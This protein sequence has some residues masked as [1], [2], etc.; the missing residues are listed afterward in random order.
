MI[1]DA[2]S[3]RYVCDWWIDEF[4]TKSVVAYPLMVKGESIGAM[5]VETENDEVRFPQEEIDT[6]WAIAQQVAV[7]IEN[8]RLYEREQ[9]QRERSE[10]LRKLLTAAS[11]TLSL[12]QVCVRVCEAALDL[13]AGDNVSVF[14]LNESNDGFVP[15]S[16]VGRGSGE[17]TKAFFSPPPDVLYSEAY[18]NGDRM[19]AKLRK[20]LVA[21]NA[22]A[23]PYTHPW[24]TNTFGLKSIA[25]Y[26]L[27]V[28][29]RAIGLMIAS[30]VEKRCQF[31]EEEVQTL[32]AVAGQA[33]IMIENARLYER[34]AS[35]AAE[36]E[37]SETDC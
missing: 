20:P 37:R 15:V 35:A 8:A 12:R 25:Y 29:G 5:T 13:T 26:P 21:E 16:S 9:Q 10:K 22:T 36:R 1:E 7:I 34:A 28:K 11:A 2:P 17:D 30:G 24:W 14:L 6:L 19:L 31:R 32:N 18:R 33:A 3:S 4:G 23:S 27:R